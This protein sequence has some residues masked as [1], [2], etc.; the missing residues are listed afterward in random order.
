MWFDVPVILKKLVSLLSLCALALSLACNHRVLRPLP[1]PA[2]TRAEASKLPTPE[3][4]ARALHY[5][6]SPDTG[7]A[8][9]GSS[10]GDSRPRDEE[11]SSSW[12]I[13]IEAHGEGA[14]LQ[15][16]SIRKIAG[17]RAPE[18]IDVADASGPL[19]VSHTERDRRSEFTL[20]RTPIAPLKLRYRL[21]REPVG[22]PAPSPSM[23]SGA[24]HAAAE[25]SSAESASRPSISADQPLSPELSLA[26]QHLVADTDALLLVPDR[27]ATVALPI[28]I[29]VN[30]TAINPT[31][32]ENPNAPPQLLLATTL[33]LGGLGDA[34]T[35]RPD[36]LRRTSLI[37]GPLE[38]A[39]FDGFGGNDRFAFIGP[40][41][42]DVRWA[43][44]EIAGLRSAVDLYFGV[45][46]EAPYTTLVSLRHHAPSEPPFTAH[47]RSQ[48]LLLRGDDRAT[49][50]ATARMTVGQALVQRWLGGRVR[51]LEE[52]NQEPGAELLWFSGGVARVIAWKLLYGLGA[53]SDDDYTAEINA[54][55]GL[56]ATSPH[57]ALDRDKLATLAD[58]GG[59]ESQAARALLLARGALYAVDLNAKIRARSSG[60]RALSVLVNAVVAEALLEN[61]RDLPRALWTESASAELGAPMEPGFTAAIDRGLRPALAKDAL[62]PCFRPVKA[63]YRRFDLGFRDLT[64]AGAT[65]PSIADLDPEGPAA[66]AG[67]RSDDLLRSLTYAPGDPTTEVNLTLDRNGQT[68]PLRYLPAGPKERGIAWE[69]IPSVPDE[70]CGP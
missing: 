64:R 67:L 15:A 63:T 38:W 35:L 14:E 33:G 42:F 31:P 46:S 6:L 51:L 24:V 5:T 53:L 65:A 17:L 1:P 10:S 32:S 57:R 8:R 50:G 48:G 54:W 49:W 39:R 28:R 11:E 62:G 16:W 21:R 69:R 70:L 58:A 34:P 30:A 29:E 7:H 27:L 4:Q 68:I 37:A 9:G 61:I 26:P 20:D 23:D 66:R 40:A 36:D 52:P 3:P 60:S 43:A 22:A 45:L 41:V 25:T 18:I 12:I 19:S 56:L 44:A 59:P 47:L 2:E 55:E 13:E